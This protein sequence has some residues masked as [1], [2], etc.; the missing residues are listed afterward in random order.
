MA[1]SRRVKS[2][3]SK[4]RLA[5]EQLNSECGWA[6]MIVG[7]APVPKQGP[8]AAGLELFLNDKDGLE[9]QW[10]GGRVRRPE[11][12][13]KTT[14]YSYPHSPLDD[15][16]KLTPTKVRKEEER[17][18]LSN[19]FV[20]PFG[21]TLNQALSVPCMVM[22]TNINKNMHEEIE[23]QTIST[24]A[25]QISLSP[26]SSQSSLAVLN[27]NTSSSQPLLTQSA[28]SN[29]SCA[30][31]EPMA[32]LSRTQSQFHCSLYLQ[33]S[34]FLVQPEIQSCPSLKE[35]S[36]ELQLQISTKKTHLFMVK[37]ETS[38]VRGQTMSRIPPLSM[39]SS[40]KQTGIW[41]KV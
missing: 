31:M 26:H 38:L 22:D 27:L 39:T 30:I 21:L 10:S 37:T 9:P 15:D 25:E 16:K 13:A 17:S 5:G 7:A 24:I 34:S 1:R 11:M 2:L 33:K 14:L 29:Q 23:S 20:S 3:L 12:S 41:S 18:T 28:A 32:V 35:V 40:T 19:S 4:L 6:V 36:S 8:R